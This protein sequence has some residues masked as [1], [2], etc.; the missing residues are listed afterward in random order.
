MTIYLGVGS[1]TEDIYTSITRATSLKVS[2]GGTTTAAGRD[3]TEVY[4]R[5]SMSC[6]GD[7]KVAELTTVN[8]C[9][10]VLTNGRRTNVKIEVVDMVAKLWMKY[11]S[12]SSY[13]EPILEM[14]LRNQ[15]TGYV[16][17][18]CYGDTQI[19]TNGW[20]RTLTP[21]YSLDSIKIK[22]L[23][24]DPKICDMPAFKSNIY[25]TGSDYPYVDKDRDTDLLENR[26]DQ[27]VEMQDGGCLG[28]I[29]QPATVVLP[30]IACLMAVM[31]IRRKNRNEEK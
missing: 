4:K 11:D 20:E 28:S 9:D 12:D 6:A 26:L 2:I 13:G 19:D 3:V 8:P 18:G 29:A 16:R 5:V 14:Q 17:F 27:S 7:S 23:D 22:N 31:I 25:D 21:N 24:E 10:K 30:T 1:Y 15:P